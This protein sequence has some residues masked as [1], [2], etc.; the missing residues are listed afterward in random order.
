MYVISGHDLT[1]DEVVHCHRSTDNLGHTGPSIF[2]QPGQDVG[3]L[4]VDVD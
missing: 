3:C 1:L 2:R 4:L